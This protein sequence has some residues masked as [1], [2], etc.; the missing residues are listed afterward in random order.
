[1]NKTIWLILILFLNVLIH[2][3][4]GSASVE[5]MQLIS[6][7]PYLSNEFQL[8]DFPMKPRSCKSKYTDVVWYVP[9]REGNVSR[10]IYPNESL[11]YFISTEYRPKCCSPTCDMKHQYAVA[12]NPLDNRIGKTSGCPCLSNEQLVYLQKRGGNHY[13]SYDN[14]I[15]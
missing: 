5:N 1:M 10:L 9:N 2:V 6:P 14:T 7:M 4:V 11:F 8:K 12:T 13:D 15:S 3:V